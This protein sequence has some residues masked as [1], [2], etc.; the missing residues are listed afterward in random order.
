MTVLFPPLNTNKLNPSFNKLVVKTCFTI[1]LSPTQR[2]K[3][4]K[5][6]RER[7]MH[8]KYLP[9]AF[10]D[11]MKKKKEEYQLENSHQTYQRQLLSLLTN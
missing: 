5:E 8:F 10:T 1:I 4:K 11:L 2:E 9:N 3:E 7:V 6:K